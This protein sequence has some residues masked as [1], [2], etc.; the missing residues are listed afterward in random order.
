[1]QPELW[2]ILMDKPIWEGVFKDFRDINST[3]KGFYSTR[4]VESS[5]SKVKNYNELVNKNSTI[6][7]MS[8]RPT[9]L[10]IVASMMEL[11]TL[12]ANRIVDFGGGLAFSYLSFAGCCANAKRLEYHIVESEEICDTG[13][14]L[15]GNI[16]NLF[17]Y[18]E[19]KELAFDRAGI[20][21]LNSVLQYIENWRLLIEE[22]LELH[23]NYFLFD[24][25]PGGDIPTFASVQ[26]YYDSKIP[27]W[28][29]NIDELIS[30]FAS[31][32]YTVQFKSKFPSF[33]LG[34]TQEYPM[35]NFPLK[36]Q[37]GYPCTLLFKKITS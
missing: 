13:K 21:Y 18:S 10:P 20:V 34:K 25:V 32:G 37:L 17:F 3:G 12:T 22:L 23:P 9:S 19:P 30:F 1:L 4:W 29:L 11:E 28:F 8:I 31:K 16:P 7:P 26:N 5:I 14:D 35:Q 2:S 33:I 6:P 36:Y 15:F 24:D 27:C